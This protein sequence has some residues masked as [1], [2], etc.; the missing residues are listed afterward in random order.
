MANP[1]LYKL[2]Q[3]TEKTCPDLCMQLR[4]QF[5]TELQQHL[6]LQPSTQEILSVS[7]KTLQSI[8]KG[9]P[10]KR[11]IAERL[12]QTIA[13][14]LANSLTLEAAIITITAANEQ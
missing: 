13:H 4:V 10:E 11:E 14:G 8:A 2:I 12:F 9:D 3:D 5:N 7:R 1:V 6:N